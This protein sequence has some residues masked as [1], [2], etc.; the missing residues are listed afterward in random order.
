MLP[1]LA[2]SF[3]PYR[4]SGVVYGCLLNDRGGLEALADALHSPP[5]KAPPKAP[6][7]YLKP[8]NTLADAG[9]AALVPDEG[10][11]QYSIGASLAI[12]I[13]HGTR[14]A[15]LA[16]AR[17]AI[18]GFTLACDLSVPHESYY[19]PAVRFKAR[20]GSCLLGPAVIALE[21]A[22][23]SPGGLDLTVSIDRQAVQHAP[24]AGMI[25]E[26]AQLIADI[27]EFL[28]L[29]GGDVVLLGAS[30]PSPLAHAGQVFAIEAP[31]L[32]RLHG[33]LRAANAMAGA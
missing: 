20:D 27:S 2:F 33:S 21:E 13:K 17:E 23:A 11:R 29:D 9:F 6:I 19:R 4:L 22:M 5:Y 16:K 1:R 24:L 8:R 18:A 3:L 32:G 12:V 30:W 10:S 14:R 31:S 7:L 26:P 25:R 15:T 28:T